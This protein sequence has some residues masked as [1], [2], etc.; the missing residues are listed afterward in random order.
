LERSS[1]VNQIHGSLQDHAPAIRYSGYGK[2][3]IV[4]KFDANVF[5]GE[6]NKEELTMSFDAQVE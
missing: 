5:T 2:D 4:E 6:Q 1:R 3:L